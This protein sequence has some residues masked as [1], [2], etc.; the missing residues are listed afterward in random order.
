MN[1]RKN[2]TAEMQF[3]KEDYLTQN[4][5]FKERLKYF[6]HDFSKDYFGVFII[7]FKENAIDVFNTSEPVLPMLTEEVSKT[8]SYEEFVDF[9]CKQYVSETDRQMLKD[10]FLPEKVKEI[11]NNNGTAI[12]SAHQNYQDR[13]CPT[14]F[15]FTDVSF[16]HDGTECILAIRFKEDVVRQQAALKKQDDMVK[17]LVQDYNAI[18]HINLDDDTF[19]IMHAKNVVNE[20]LY[21]YAYRKLPFTTAMNKFIDDMVSE[22]DRETLRKISTCAY[23]KERLEKEDSYSMRFQVQPTRGMQYFD[24]RIMRA[25]TSE[26][27]HFAIMT[28][29]N[30]DEIAREEM[31]AQFEIENANRQLAKA[32]KEAEAAND[33][34][35]HFLANVSHDMRTPLNA[36]LGYDA[37]ALEADSLEVKTDYLKKIGAAGKSLNSLINDTLDLQKIEQGVVSLNPSPVSCSV[38]VDAVLTV[39]RPLMEAKHIHFIFDNSKAVYATINVDAPHV[40]EI[41]VNLLSNAAKFTPE[42][43]EVRMAIECEKETDDAIFDKVTILDNGAGIS[44]EFLPKIYEPFSQERTAA[45]QGIGGSGLG[46]SIVKRLVTLMNGQITVMSEL[47]KGTEFTVYLKFPKADIASSQDKAQPSINLSGRKI[48][49]CEDNEMNREIAK[50]ILDK[51]KVVTMD[52]V[53]GLDGYKKFMASGKNEFS[54]ILMDLRMPVM[55]GYETAKKIRSSDH[56]NAKDIPIIAVSADAYADDIQRTKAAGMNSY[57]SKP[58]DAEK[59]LEV[60]QTEIDSFEKS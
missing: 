54:A 48:L 9:Y 39:I 35:S 59:M 56:P 25:R 58:I 40:E 28:S 12:F 29:R 51:Y 1:N 17:T 8:N 37:L 16:A 53:N 55:D 30:V 26:K 14:E 11:L 24:M 15:T 34:K 10:Q 36:I 50:A 5:E 13:N 38:V 3:S 46:L 4:N 6:I 33:A 57:L 21:D 43:G 49:L 60:L 52:A 23:M 41:F 32:L 31:Q 7:D 47:G 19:V 2:D 22:K 45:T 20:E 44:K 42:G 18:Y 27:G